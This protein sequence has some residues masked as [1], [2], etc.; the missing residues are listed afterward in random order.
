LRP[1]DPDAIY[2]PLDVGPNHRD[3][4][5]L[6]LSDVESLDPALIQL[7]SDYQK[8]QLIFPP[9]LTL[10]RHNELTAWGADT[11]SASA[12]GL[13]WTFHLHRGMKWSDGTPIDA[14]T[15][16]YSI[17]RSLDPCTHSGAASVLAGQRGELIKGAM[18]F[19]GSPCPAGA[20]ASPDNLIGK[21][22]LVADPF[23]L[24]LILASP[25]AYFPMALT[26]PEA[27]AQPKQLIAR[28]GDKWTDHLADGTGF[29]GNLFKIT[30]WD[31][32]GHL[33]MARNESFWGAKPK[34]GRVEWILYPDHESAWRDYFV[35][36]GDYANVPASEALSARSLPGFQEKSSLSVSYIVPNWRIAP[37]DDL[38]VRQAF[39][40]ALDRRDVARRATSNTVPPTIHMV[41]QG[42]P[43]YA[44]GLTDPEGRG[45]NNALSPDTLQAYALW[46]EYLADKFG[47]DATKAPAVTFCYGADLPNAAASVPLYLEQWRAAMP[48]L[49]ITA[50]ATCA[51]AAQAQ[52]A[53][54]LQ[55]TSGTWSMSCPDPHAI[56][57]QVARTG[58]LANRSGIS[59]PEADA[60]MDQADVNPNPTTRMA[61]YHQAEQLLI[62]EVAWVPVSQGVNWYATRPRVGGYTERTVGIAPLSAWQSMWIYKYM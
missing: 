17:N 42:M 36:K 26:A 60:L 18:A 48:G 11:W 7:S 12:D 20:T 33:N 5:S 8:A 50:S 6:G 16:A 28:F 55:L 22:I 44:A 24:K 27:W 2:Q 43:G 1:I 10:D 4:E 46:K 14:T 13:T 9:L 39:F 49:R 52:T 53:S 59:V 56:L 19:T 31:H 62:D 58:A 3:V 38:R 23:T 25:A 61:Q 45:E 37:F 41:P 54:T 32:G 21:R 34:F 51:H 47:G 35:G 30:L 40:L 29:G 15:Y 57:P